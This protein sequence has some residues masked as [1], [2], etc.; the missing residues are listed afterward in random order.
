MDAAALMRC[1]PSPM[2]L[3]EI[4]QVLQILS[5]LRGATAHLS[6][7]D[8]AKLAAAALSLENAI[9]TGSNAEAYADQFTRLFYSRQ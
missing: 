4:I 9:P 5:E 6:E 8:A 1:L 7:K 2:A 3:A